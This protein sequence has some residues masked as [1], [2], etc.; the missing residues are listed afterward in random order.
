MKVIYRYF[1]VPVPVL[2]DEKKEIEI[3]IGSTIDELMNVLCADMEEASSEM[4]QKA[5]FLVNN[6]GAK[7]ET[8]LNDNDEII[9]LNPIGGG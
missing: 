3:G 5:T 1:G 2:T 4:L 8:V 6:I 9:I 7:R